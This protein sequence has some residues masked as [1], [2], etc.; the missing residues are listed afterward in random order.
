MHCNIHVSLIHAVGFGF[1][2][3]CLRCLY[4]ISHWSHPDAKLTSHHVQ[5]VTGE[6]L[7]ITMAKEDLYRPIFT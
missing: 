1:L 7:K 4:I 6:I 2:F 3:N 5:A